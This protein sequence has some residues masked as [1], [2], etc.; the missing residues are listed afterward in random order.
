MKIFLVR[1]GRS[2]LNGRP[3]HQHK[4][5]P[6]SQHGKEQVLKLAKK[7]SSL[8]IDLIISG[9]YPRV[10][11][12]SKIISK[13]IKKRILYTKLLDEWLQPSELEGKSYSDAISVSIGNECAKNIN[14]V[15][16]HYS[17]EENV[18]D[19]KN[20]VQKLVRRLSIMKQESV[21]LVTHA[22]I[23]NMFVALAV[24][25]DDITG[26]E[27]ARFRRIFSPANTGIT[28]IELIGSTFKVRTFNDCSHLG[29]M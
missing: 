25:G 5:V 23:I 22:G 29:K 19:L 15:N 7:L 6:L 24:F 11:N 21:V 3:I 4:S 8:E 1:H 10:V 12:T 18:F 13:T 26:T 17:D 16:W 14:K 9:K 20:R 2:K 28:E 27:F